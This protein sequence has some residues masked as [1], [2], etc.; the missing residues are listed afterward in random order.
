MDSGTDVFAT[1]VW[2]LR[3]FALLVLAMVLA[4][5]VL[6]P[7]VLSQRPEVYQATAQVGPNTPLL[8]S[9][10]NPLPRFA[11]SVFNNGAVEQRVRQLLH[12]DSGNVIPSRVRSISYD[13]FTCL[14]SLDRVVMRR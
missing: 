8:L 1:L 2:G 14:P 13:Q 9:N 6:V 11:E 4:L 5:G 7:L 12:Q 3:R 10:T